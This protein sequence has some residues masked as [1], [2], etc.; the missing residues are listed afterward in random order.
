MI[1][2][3]LNMLSP[4][5]TNAN[6]L[7]MILNSM[8]PNRKLCVER[9]LVRESN[10][11]DESQTLKPLN[12]YI[13]QLG[14]N[15]V[16]SIVDCGFIL[17]QL[18]IQE[19]VI[20]NSLLEKKYLYERELEFSEKMNRYYQYSFRSK[21]YNPVFAIDFS[22]D[23]IA[24][25][26]EKLHTNYSRIQANI[27]YS[28]PKDE[29]FTVYDSIVCYKYIPFI[30]EHVYLDGHEKFDEETNLHTYDIRMPIL[31]SDFLIGYL[32]ISVEYDKDRNLTSTNIGLSL[33]FNLNIYGKLS[34]T[35]EVLVWSIHIRPENRNALSE[36]IIAKLNKK[37]DLIQTK[38]DFAKFI[39]ENDGNPLD[40]DFIIK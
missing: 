40:Q 19:L 36:E 25:V 17:P 10:V 4:T 9:I 12:Y 22:I 6:Q 24:G 29:Y 33:P 31:D 2:S 3:L 21:L 8:E 20:S 27:S 11:L 26:I 39:A 7:E 13:D 35:K 32:F 28:K 30:K 15:Q 18:Y 23:K 14:L 34:D 37:I 1:K 5:K 16:C 38:K